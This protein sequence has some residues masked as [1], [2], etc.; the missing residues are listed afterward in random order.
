MGSHLEFCNGDSAKKTSVMP[1]PDGGMVR[2]GI[3]EFNVPLD[4]VQGI[5]ETG[6]KA[7]SLTIRALV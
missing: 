2:Y 3:A 5:S 4:T 7:E 1:V 6:Q